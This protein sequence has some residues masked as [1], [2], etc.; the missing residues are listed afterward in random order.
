MVPLG[1]TW[2][3]NPDVAP[4]NKAITPPAAV[5][6]KLTENWINMKTP[7]YA[8]STLGWDGRLSGPNDGAVVTPAWA[9]GHYYP[10]GISSVGCL[11]CHSSAQYNPKSLTTDE[12]NMVSFLLPT[13]TQP[14]T[15]LPPPHSHGDERALVLNEPG[16]TAWLKWF[17]SRAGDEPM[18]SGQVALDYDMVTAFKAIPM[19]QAAYRAMKKEDAA[20][21]SLKRKDH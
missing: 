12:P 3:G 18:D 19:W 2:G 11:G 14:P 20:K 4:T 17:Q 5:N 21:A 6:P 16:S 8:R 9:G 15:V 1:A 10:A 7:D 13:T